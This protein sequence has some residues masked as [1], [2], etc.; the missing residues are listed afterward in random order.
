[1][2]TKHYFLFIILLFFCLLANAKQISTNKAKEIGQNFILKMSN[3]NTFANNLTLIYTE[4][5]YNTINSSTINCFYIFKI[6]DKGFII[7]SADDRVSPILAYSLEN[8][9]ITENIPTNISFVLNVYKEN[10]ANTI[11][12]NILPT[13]KVISEWSELSKKN[14][15]NRTNSANSNFSTTQAVNPLIQTHWAQS[16]FYN[17]LC[18]GGSVTGCVATSMAQVMKYWDYPTQGTGSHSY[19]HPTYGTLT[20]DFGNTTYNWFDMPN[21][22]YSPNNS[23]ATLMNHCGVSVDMNYSPSESGASVFTATNSLKTYFNYDISTQFI[24]KSNYTDTSWLFTIENELN[25]GRPVIYAG[26]SGSLAGHAWICDGYDSN[27]YLHFNWGWGGSSDGY[28]QVNSHTYLNIQQAIIGIKPQNFNGIRLSLNVADNN[29]DLCTQSNQTLNLNVPNSTNFQSFQWVKDNINIVGANT[30]TLTATSSDIGSVFYCTGFD[31]SG[32]PFTSNKIK[33]SQSL[34][35]SGFTY[36]KNGLS[37]NFT[38]NSSCSSNRTWDF[39]DT[40]TSIT[41][42]PIKTYT[43]PAIYNVCINNTNAAGSS[44]NCKQIPIFNSWTEEMDG[45]NNAINNNVTYQ[46]G[47]CTQALK[48]TRNSATDVTQN[49]SVEYPIANWIPKQGTI[50]LLLKVNN[51]STSNGTST[52]VA[53]IFAL[54]NNSL[55]N[56]NF[57]S[58][59]SN[60]KISL[61]RYQSPSFTDITANSTSFTFN[62]WHVVSISYGNQG[63]KIAVNGVVYATNSAVNY[64]MIANS[65]NFILGHI[66]Y[67]DYTNLWYGFE[68]LVDK[69]RFSYAQNDF[70]LSVPTAPTAITNQSFCNGAMVADLVATG[71]N[72][73]WYANPTVGNPLNSTTLLVSGNYFVSQTVNGC[74][75]SRTPVAVTITTTQPPTTNSIQVLCS[76]ATVSNLF[77]YSNA[78]RWYNTA[79]GGSALLAT[80]NVVSGTYYV[81][82]ILNGCESIRLAVNVTVSN[83]TNPVVDSSYSSDSSSITYSWQSNASTYDLRYNELGTTNYV[84]INGITSNSYTISGLLPCTKYVMSVRAYCG[85]NY[86]GYFGRV[87]ET[88]NNDSSA[89]NVSYIQDFNITQTTSSNPFCQIQWK[90]ISGYSGILNDI[91]PNGNLNLNCNPTAGS[92]DDVVL[93]RGINLTQGTTYNIS[94]KYSNTEQNQIPVSLNFSTGLD[95]NISTHTI[96]KSYSPNTNNGISYNTNYITENLQFTPITSGTYYFGFS[97]ISGLTSGYLHF[98]DF[99]VTTTLNTSEFNMDNIKIYPNPTDNILFIDTT[100]KQINKIEIFDLQSRLLQTINENK[101]KYQIDISNY[102]SATYLLKITTDKGSQSVKILKK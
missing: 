18:P 91:Y 53:T 11:K 39:G 4:N 7:V 41:N 90:Q 57:L 62:N 52:S 89:A 19:S 8:N 96:L 75:S 34:P 67:N 101:D 2:K 6:N 77:P 17:D 74:E 30:S 27:D 58:V 31:S 22:V 72:L 42:N 24:M 40:T 79:M 98:D 47:I 55:T 66:K 59:Y 28:F 56:S 9:F 69:I 99:S 16:P 65:F 26:Y 61:R 81:S 71:T 46:N 80:T 86:S 60:G 5:E 1:M 88:K 84:F 20:A 50:E 87:F 25:A 70:Q 54:G 29:V 45:S 10:I 97:T 48:F 63:T 23:V 76:G 32:T 43:T 102:T 51:G 95:E 92:A 14:Y 38:N 21:E 12:N 36:T 35:I 93:S 68:G 3:K 13:Q 85:G 15:S 44:Q 49:T 82:Q 73:N 37:V 64:E 94:Y 33:I 83:I 100:E 78:I